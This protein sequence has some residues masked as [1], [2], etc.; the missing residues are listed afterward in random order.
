MKYAY[1]IAFAFAR[2]SSINPA[3]EVN[4]PKLYSNV[5]HETSL[6]SLKELVNRDRES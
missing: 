6:P 5:V 3:L 1:A 2:V 4:R